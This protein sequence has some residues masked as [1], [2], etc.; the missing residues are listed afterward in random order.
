[1][2]ALSCACAVQIAVHCASNLHIAI[3]TANSSYYEIYHILA[4]EF[5]RDVQDVQKFALIKTGVTMNV[6]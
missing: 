2:L 5:L 1:M 4:R 6:A 3:C